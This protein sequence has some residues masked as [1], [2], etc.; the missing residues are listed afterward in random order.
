MKT[1]RAIRFRGGAT[2]AIV[3]TLSCALAGTPAV[4]Q[5]GAVGNGDWSSAATWTNGLPAANNTA[6]IGSTTPAGAA[7]TATVT[8]SQDTTGGRL[9]WLRVRHVRDN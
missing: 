6:Y 1:A 4:A 5:T 8:L 9:P 7:T 2:A 3:V